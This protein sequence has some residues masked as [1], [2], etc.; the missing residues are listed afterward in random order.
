MVSNYLYFDKINK[1][2][3]IL[4]HEDLWDSNCQDDF[5]DYQIQL[6]PIANNYYNG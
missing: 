6:D 3:Q 1:L 5:Y 2:I 4:S